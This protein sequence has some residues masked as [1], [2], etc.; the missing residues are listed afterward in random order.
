ML[1]KYPFTPIK[2][3]KNVSQN[4]VAVDGRKVEVK[5]KIEL[6]KQFLPYHYYKTGGRHY[7]SIEVYQASMQD[8]QDYANGQMTLE[9]ERINELKQKAK[10]IIDQI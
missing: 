10:Q 9:L 2:K 8:I 6:V 7:F 5:Q 3:V 4:R 1:N